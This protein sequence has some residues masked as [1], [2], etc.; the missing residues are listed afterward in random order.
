[1]SGTT[2]AP[3]GGGLAA[4]IL[5]AVA[6]LGLQPT[7]G[8]AQVGTAQE[9]GPFA[10]TGGTVHTLAGETIEDGTVVIRGGR[11]TAVGAGTAAPSDV[12]IVDAAGLHVYP[13]MFDSNT[14]LGLTE[15]GA[16]D[17]T[18]DVEEL[19]DYNPHLAA[20][21]AVH[22]AS[23]H[24]PVARANGITHTL[25]VP[26]GGRIPGRASLIHLGGWTVEEMLGEES[27]G[28]IIDFPTIRTRRF[29]FETFEFVERP[30]PEAKEEYEE[31]LAELAEWIEAAE[32]YAR[33]T[34]NGGSVE[35][36]RRLEALVPVVRGELPAIVSADSERDIRNAVAFAEEHGLRVILAGTGGGFF[37]GSQEAAK[38]ADLLAE[39]E[40]PVILAPTQRMPSDADAPYDEPYAAPG[41]LHEAGV[42][43]AF[44]TYNSSDVRT[45]PYEAAMAVPYGLPRE[46]ALKAVTIN[47]AR[48]FG[49]DDRLGTIEVGKIANLI[50]TDG[51]PL[52]ITTRVVHLFIQGQKTSLENK[53]Q[54]LY[55]EYRAR[56]RRRAPGSEGP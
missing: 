18:N 44:A 25:S 4:A 55:E 30:Y 15:I 29:D 16:V 34:E 2:K 38:V 41:V 49:V 21:T 51:D 47:P 5:A 32:H 37:T 24:I 23:E 27:S 14:R 50:V 13:G 8:T 17:V 46:E 39:K 54:R 31:N 6:G 53:H 33:A 3:W 40:I 9:A 48:I 20:Y 1:M 26:G 45:L 12:R 35:R 28:M 42:P 52:E 22:P 19:G 10:L 11:I 36:S 43:F 56:P 7:P